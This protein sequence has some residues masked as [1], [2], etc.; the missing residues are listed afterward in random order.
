MSNLAPGVEPFMVYDIHK[1]EMVPLTQKHLE[2]L[3]AVERAYGQMRLKSD[4]IQAELSSSIR[5]LRGRLD[6]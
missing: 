1:D 5:Q 6:A 2:Y 3:L 4:D